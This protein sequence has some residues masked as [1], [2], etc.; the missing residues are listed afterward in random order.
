MK[1]KDTKSSKSTK[2]TKSIIKTHSDESFQIIYNVNKEASILSDN[3]KLLLKNI[4]SKNKY[5]NIINKLNII[6]PID[7][8]L[9]IEHIKNFIKKKNIIKIFKLTEF[10]VYDKLSLKKKGG[11]SLTIPDIYNNEMVH[12]CSLYKGTQG[13]YNNNLDNYNILQQFPTLFNII[14]TNNIDLNAYIY[15]SNILNYDVLKNGYNI[16]TKLTQSSDFRRTIT[17]KEYNK[18]MI[19]GYELPQF[20]YHGDGIE[21]NNFIQLQNIYLAGLSEKEKNIIADYVRPATYNLINIFM[22]EFKSGYIQKYISKHGMFTRDMANSFCDYIEYFIRNGTINYPIE[23]ISNIKE[24]ATDDDAEPIYNTISED[25]WTQII[26]MYLNDLNTIILNA[27]KSTH[28]FIT[29]RGVKEDYFIP[30]EFNAD[31]IPVY[32]SNRIISI[33]ISYIAAKTFYDYGRDPAASTL[34]R[35]AIPKGCS[36]LFVTPVAPIYHKYE[37]EFILPVNQYFYAANNDWN[38]VTAYNSYLNKNNICLFDEDKINSKDLIL[39]AI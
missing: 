21:L 11:T 31:N 28:D 26:L 13:T 8:N 39:I 2:S 10:G 38:R 19:M 5:L 33:S 24:K 23:N 16:T 12:F 14:T 30:Q 9:I 37:M 7:I 4:K 20:I 22:T 6:K 3:I 35:I 32:K 17:Y 29:Y 15:I 34:Y 36:M 25:I 18:D 27:P 1:N